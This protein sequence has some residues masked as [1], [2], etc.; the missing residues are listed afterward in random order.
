MMISTKVTFNVGG[1]EISEAQFG[2]KL[3]EAATEA[4]KEQLR[5][6]IEGIRCPFHNKNAQALFEDG[7]E[8]KYKIKGCCE[9]FTEEVKKS[10]RSQG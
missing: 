8:V 10:F 2:E 5:A 7:P 4:V 1:R 9:A 6:K 3:S